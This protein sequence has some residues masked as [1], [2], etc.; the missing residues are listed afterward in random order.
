MTRDPVVEEVR[1]RGR[2]L[3]TRYANDPKTLLRALAEHARTHPEG[4]VDTIK[5]VP[6]GTRKTG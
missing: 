6:E 4:V 1:A 3:T 2:A 5:I